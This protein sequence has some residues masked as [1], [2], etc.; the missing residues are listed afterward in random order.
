M[1]G[2]ISDSSKSSNSSKSSESFDSE[3]NEDSITVFDSDWVYTEKVVVPLCVE[4]L[5][6]IVYVPCKTPSETKNNVEKSPALVEKNESY[7]SLEPSGGI[8]SIV[9]L[10]DFV[11]PEPAIVT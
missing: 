2:T 7:N 6:K 10:L 8:I 5:A 9:I 4:S 11:A 3:S 1:V